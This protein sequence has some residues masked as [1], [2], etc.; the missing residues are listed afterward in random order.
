MTREHAGKARWART[1]AAG[2]WQ[3]ATELDRDRTGSWE[4]R[5]GRR[6]AADRLRTEAARFELMGRRFDPTPDDQAA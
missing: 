4:D 6:R 1:K 5:A 3:Q 2:L